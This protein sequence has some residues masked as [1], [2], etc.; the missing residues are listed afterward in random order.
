VDGWEHSGW[1]G[2]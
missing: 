1:M 2:T